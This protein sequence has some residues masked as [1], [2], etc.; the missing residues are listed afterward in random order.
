MKEKNV[1]ILIIVS[2]AII[3]IS[4]IGGTYAYLTMGVNVTN[5]TYNN[6][7]TYCL[8]INYSINNVDTSSIK[9]VINC[10]E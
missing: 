2:I 4:I 1:K 5:G 9:K 10:M 8:D 6:V 7:G 3:G